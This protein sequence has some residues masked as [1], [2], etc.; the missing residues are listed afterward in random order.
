MGAGASGRAG[1]SLRGGGGGG[2]GAGGA[3]GE[4]V[5]SVGKGV[6]GTWNANSHPHTDPSLP[7]RKSN[8]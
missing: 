6:E 8:G 1:G 4:G 7:S 5:R 2:G 3:E